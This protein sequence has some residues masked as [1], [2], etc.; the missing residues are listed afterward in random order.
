MRAVLV[1]LGL[2]VLAGCGAIPPQSSDRAECVPLFGQYDQVARIAPP[3]VDA[4]RRNGDVGYEA[5]LSRLQVL[6]VQN[7]C[8]TR[9]RDLGPLEAIASERGAAG[10]PRGGPPLGRPVAVHAGALTS[11]EDAARAIAFFRAFGLR[12]TSVG[13]PFLGRRVYAGPARTQGELDAILALA[14]EA[15]FVA[16]YPARYFRF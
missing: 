11:E 3:L 8:Q 15:G 9:S 1:A 6:L 2:G 10:V 16:S 14:F 12:A 5:W 4:R 13:D 7:D